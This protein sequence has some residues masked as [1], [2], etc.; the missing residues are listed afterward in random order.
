MYKIAL[1]ED[2]SELSLLI[3]TMLKRYDYE[4]VVINDF[5]HAL[6]RLIE[7]KADVVLLDINLPY[8][9]GF[10]ICK[11]VRKKSIVPIIM[12]SARNN[13][14]DQILG[15]E[16]GADDYVIKPFS[17]EV[18][19]SKIKASIRRAYGALTHEKSNVVF[20]NFSLDYRTF[21]VSNQGNEIELTKSEF[22]LLKY[23]IENLNELVHRESLLR[24]LWDDVSFIDNNTLNVNISRIK[25]KLKE[26]GIE[27]VIQTKRGYGYRFVPTA[28]EKVNE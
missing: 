28:L 5:E 10:H 4:V 20:G 23:L 1:V 16:L 8:V 12:I 27:E 18:L 21:I 14:S 2:D 6:E 24:E 22:K 19:H 15:M 7:L 3:S 26:I 13:D 17:V 9:D 25:N 11:H